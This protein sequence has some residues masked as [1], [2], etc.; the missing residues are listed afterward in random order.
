MAWLASI[1]ALGNAAAGL[2][3]A[4]DQAL[5]K[6]ERTIDRREISEPP[7]WPWVFPFDYAKLARY[8]A[9]VKV[10]LDRPAEALVAFT[11]SLSV[12]HPAPKQRAVIMLE[13]ATAARQAGMFEKDRDRV[14]EAFRLA[15][16]AIHIGVTYSSERVIQHA[17]GF[18]R[19]YGGP[20]TEHVADFDEQLRSTLP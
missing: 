18:R 6:A 14:R 17:R 11:E 13:V 12:P 16:E 7:P 5:I 10:R 2:G 8:R 1:E 3:A 19:G 9:L 4:A 15:A 20:I